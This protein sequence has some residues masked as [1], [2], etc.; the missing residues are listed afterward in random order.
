MNKMTKI[1]ENV[2]MPLGRAVS[3]GTF[4]S[5]HVSR[6]SAKEID[7]GTQGSFLK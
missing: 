3:R 6:K 5:M 1:V 7:S 2:G 4:L